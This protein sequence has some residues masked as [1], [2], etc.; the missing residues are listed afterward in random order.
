MPYTNTFDTLYYEA[1]KDARFEWT[2]VVIPFA[3]GAVSIPL[4][5]ITQMMDEKRYPY[6]KG[7]NAQTNSYL[8]IRLFQPDIVLLQTPY[9]TQRISPLYS[10][11]F[12]ASF[13]RVYHIS[14]GC[15][16]VDYDYPPYD[17]LLYIQDRNCTTLSEN[18]HFTQILD[19]YHIH[20][21]V[22]IGYIKCDKYLNYRHHP[23]FTFKPR[24]DFEHILAWKPRWI[25]TIGESNFVSYIDFFIEYAQKHPRTLLYFIWHDL[26][27]NELVNNRRIYTAKK[28][29]AIMQKMQDTANIKII[30]QGDFL[31]DVFNADIFIGDYCSTIMEF[32]LT[33][34]PV[35]YT[36]CEVVLSN[37]GKQ[38]LKG[39]YV[40]NNVSEMT[41]RLQSLLR[42][43][44][45]L[46]QQ[47]TANIALLSDQHPGQT[48]AQYCLAYF[49]SLDY[50]APIQT[51][52]KL[53]ENKIKLSAPQQ[54]ERKDKLYYKIWKHLDKKLRRKGII[55]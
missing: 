10:S 28:F 23:D 29:Q 53:P 18:T 21:T 30:G 36:P 44:D 17:H 55:K 24:P 4:E 54:L 9:D 49:K 11:A 48:N 25:G 52:C 45:P 8:D 20:P 5:K 37:Y 7:Y 34:K 35:I 13:A 16:M 22:S 41:E 50:S 2:F 39:Y 43:E 15:S 47:R 12:F 46:Q 1:K 33:G 3:Q 42:G 32:S 40:V 27:Y 31:D 19:K 26:M 14:Y 38:I 51:G 6:M